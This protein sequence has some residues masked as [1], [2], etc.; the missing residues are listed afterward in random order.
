MGAKT[1]QNIQKGLTVEK[2]ALV[3]DPNGIIIELVEMKK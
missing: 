2:F 1:I 3:E